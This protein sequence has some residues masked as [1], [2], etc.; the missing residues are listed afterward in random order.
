LIPAVL[1]AVVLPAAGAPVITQE[2]APQIAGAGST[3]AFTASATGTTHVQWFKDG[4]PIA[5]ATAPVYRLAAA[6]QADSGVYTAE[7]ADASGAVTTHPARLLVTAPWS[8]PTALI[9]DFEAAPADGNAVADTT[10]RTTGKLEKSPVP[11]LTAGPG[12]A[13]G[14]AW[15]FGG[16]EAFVRVASNP[17]LRSL[18]DVESTAGLTVA[19]WVNGARQ[20]SHRRLMGLGG[21]L[22]ITSG[23]KGGT[24][25]VL[26]FGN[27]AN[28]PRLQ[29]GTPAETLN[30]NWHHVVATIDFTASHDNVRLYVDGALKTKREQQFNAGF[31]SKGD[32]M[33]GARDNGGSP[34][35][36][37][38]DQVAFFTRALSAEEIATLR[39]DGA[40]V[41]Y[42]PVVQAAANTPF[43][44]APERVL[45]LLGS[46]IDDGRPSGL[47][48]VTWSKVSGPGKVVFSNPAGAATRAEF[49]APGAYVLRLTASD[50]KLSSSRDVTV[51]YGANAA[52]VALARAETP[53]VSRLPATVHLT[54]GGQDDGFPLNPG[55]LS[56]R[57]TQVSGPGQARLA[58]PDAVRTDVDLPDSA[59]GVY[60]FRL[61]VSDGALSNETEVR[62]EVAANLPPVVHAFST[63]PII[64]FAE[65]GENRFALDAS[66]SDDGLPAS[67]GRV[68]YDWTQVA[69]P[70]SLRFDDASAA[71]PRATVS[72]PGVYQLRLTVSDGALSSTAD[73]WLKAVPPEISRIVRAPAYVEPFSPTPPPFEH[74][75]IFFTKADRPA[76]AA[77]AADPLV[78]AAQD[79]LRRALATSLEDA[80]TP[81]GQAYAALKSGDTSFDTKPFVAN[82]SPSATMTGTATF[83]LYSALSGASYLAWLDDKNPA[84]LEELAAVVATAARAQLRW[85]VPETPKNPPDNGGLS[86]DVFSDLGFCYDLLYDAMTED[87][88][89]AVRS[90]LVKMTA[91]RR[92]IAWRGSDQ[93]LST[94][95]RDAHHHLLLAALAI[96]GEP[97]FDAQASADNTLALKIFVSRWGI[98]AEGF[99]REGP[100]YF[101]LGMHAG[102]LAAYAASRRGENLFVTGNLYQSPI[103]MF[104]CMSPDSDHMW[105]HGDA[106]SW[107]NGQ[108]VSAVY[109]VL[110]RVYPRDE[111]IDFAYR[112]ALKDPRLRV[113][114]PL[115]RA[116]FGVDP[117]PGNDTF[118]AAA[119]A[120]GMSLDVYSRQRGL[121]SARSDWSPDGL[122]LDF[123]NRFDTMDIGHLHAD[124]NSFYLYSHRRIWIGESGY[125][126]TDN[127]VHSTVLIDGLGQAGSTAKP[128]WPSLPGKFVEHLSTPH[129]ALFAGDARMSYTYS[130]GGADYSYSNANKGVPTPFR[131][132]DFMPD[133]F[134]PPE[135]VRY[136]NTW[137][138]RPI[139]A[140][141][142][143][144]NPVQ[145]AF[146]TTVLVRGPHPYVLV[147]D[148]IQKDG[149]P[150]SYEWSANTSQ[151]EGDVVAAPGATATEAVFLH[152]PADT[153]AGAPRLLV[154]VLE[155]KGTSPDPVAIDAD[156]LPKN[157]ARRLVIRRDDV[158]APDFKVLL[159]PHRDGEAAPVTRFEGG[160]LTVKFGDAPTD[161]WRFTVT[162]DG[163][164]RVASFTRGGGAAPVITVPKME[165]V[166][167][168]ARSTSGLPAAVVNFSP[169]AVDSAGRPVTVITQPASGSLLHVGTTTV[170]ATAVD[171]EGRVATRVFPVTVTA[172]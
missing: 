136:D 103:E 119:S 23:A 14:K 159:F 84:R 11:A 102:S 107:N 64:D 32:L 16:T 72:A 13:Q 137:A 49:S 120:K 79:A 39:R 109:D 20:G 82:Y 133:G 151:G 10:G 115:T 5:G 96:E 155:A 164:T 105:G 162:P 21:T 101:S 145:R 88:R 77:R 9:Y 127:D 62:V 134:H 50:G 40:I 75:R 48:V 106:E 144:Y 19:F 169:T 113:N 47:P 26:I 128:R 130:W 56:F 18:G 69:G 157:K 95:W 94:N 91:L 146:R 63:R 154:R 71:R 37:K 165:P 121:G 143:P 76:M 124:R 85:Y 158:V 89:A 140:E 57:W 1:A 118:A 149:A 67:P 55:R 33:I 152:T 163:R 65:G 139:N 12:K 132:V 3:V 46:V 135:P 125:H 36:V 92:T 81:L 2:P 160:V 131:W 111:M 97:G 70:G 150:H 80:D 108:G 53:V 15:D 110:K 141:P 6:K 68:S 4:D 58:R 138:A 161:E 59:P 123:D 73:V 34:M 153:A 35:Q 42:A 114:Q 41:N 7:L 45:P 51:T 116:L 66:V 122:R 148:D 166:V 27:G 30:G 24:A 93:N 54:G 52:P 156:S 87:Q 171:G 44:L 78:A 43:L 170:I 168:T 172:P 61:A 22:E 112:N 29:L 142:A 167:A 86:G 98:N 83:G 117:L 17:V 147:L 31:A 90:L 25:P 8:D 129:F 60:V 104:Y 28:I 99:N 74:P 126:G 100:G 38:L